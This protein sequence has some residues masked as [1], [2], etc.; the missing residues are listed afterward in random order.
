MERD[1]GAP[2]TAGSV[3]AWAL[4]AA[5]AVFTAL[6]L[7]LLVA[8]TDEVNRSGLGS[9]PADAL[10]ALAYLAASGLGALVASRHPRNPIGWLFC[11]G[12][13]ALV[14][15]LVA[16]RGGLSDEEQQAGSHVAAR[17]YPLAQDG[18]TRRVG[19]TTVPGRRG[20]RLG[21]LPR[22]ELPSRP[23]AISDRR[24]HARTRG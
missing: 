7:V 23:G 21:R 16:V 13:L 24:R 6:N 14:Q 8:N 9:P 1:G 22:A 12:G 19:R 2:K 10:A 20:M 4:S 3:R 15:Q 11:V 5:A 18:P 17:E